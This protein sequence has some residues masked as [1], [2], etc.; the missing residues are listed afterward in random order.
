MFGDSEY[1][2][3]PR[4]IVYSRPDETGNSKNEFTRGVE[5][6]EDLGG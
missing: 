4:E 5:I 3:V 6:I 1:E 2:V